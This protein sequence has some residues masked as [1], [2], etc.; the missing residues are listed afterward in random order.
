M[1]SIAIIFITIQYDMDYVQKLKISSF[2][3]L[4]AQGQYPPDWRVTEVPEKPQDIWDE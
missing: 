4:I 2:H 3:S 1:L